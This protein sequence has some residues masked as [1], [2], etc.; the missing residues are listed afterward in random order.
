MSI[1]SPGSEQGDE[2]WVA[3]RALEALAA[4][5][6]NRSVYAYL[7]AFSDID[8]GYFVR[9]GVVDRLYNPRPAF[10][11]LKHLTAGLLDSVADGEFQADDESLT[12]RDG[13]GR[14]HVLVLDEN[15]SRTLETA[16]AGRLIDLRSGERRALSAPLESPTPPYLWIAD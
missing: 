11:A 8:R 14:R 5:A 7:D 10:H 15:A 6:G 2:A 16:G 9:Q 3:A 13:A 1:G 12:L 4:A